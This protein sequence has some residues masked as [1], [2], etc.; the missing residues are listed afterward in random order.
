M[1]LE[2]E[3][4]ALQPSGKGGPELYLLVVAGDASQDVFMKEADYVATLFEQRFGTQGHT[5]QLINNVQ[6]AHETPI[7]SVTSLQRALKRIGAVMDPTK[8][9]LFLY[10]TSHGSPDHKFA[11]Q[12]GSM[13]FKELDPQRLR[14]LLDQSGI[15]RRVLVISACY[16]GGFVDALKSD[17]TL[18]IAAAAADRSSFG[19]SNEA[20]FTYFGKAYFEE[21]L[22][23]TTSFTQAFEL[24]TASVAA[25]EKA[26]AVE[27]SKP[28]MSVGANIGAALEQF[29]KGLSP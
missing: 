4:A 9:I 14:E 5:V 3:L 17:D 18:V 16:S 28:Q 6:S 2:R 8:D 12:F 24:A 23:R 11:L 29:E 19:C 7:A 13:Q 15:R 27:P 1:V 20:D 10:L 26:D 21:A 25:R 22:N